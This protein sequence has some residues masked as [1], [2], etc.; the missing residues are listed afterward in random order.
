M[1]LIF[2]NFWNLNQKVPYMGAIWKYVPICHIVSMNVVMAV[3]IL[4]AKFQPNWSLW[5]PS[6]NPE[7]FNRKVLLYLPVWFMSKTWLIR[8]IFAGVQFKL[9]Q[10]CCVNF[11]DIWH[12]NVAIEVA[13]E[14]HSRCLY[15]GI[16][17]EILE[18]QMSVY[19]STCHRN[20]V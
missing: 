20:G 3:K 5:M 18:N 15:D 8:T 13:G 4:I 7:S 2:R 9:K 6:L 19:T 16:H 17:F 1:A 14:I 12:P 10:T 11:C